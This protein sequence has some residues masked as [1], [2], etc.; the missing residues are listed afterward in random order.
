MPTAT[1]QRFLDALDCSWDDP[2]VR[3]LAG[4]LG[5]CTVQEQDAGGVAVR[6]ARFEDGVELTFRSDRLASIVLTVSDG[7]SRMPGTGLGTVTPLNRE[8]R[9]TYPGFDD[10]V[11]GMTR[12]STRAD[13]RALLGEPLR[14]W[15]AY[16]EYL[17]GERVLS[18][19]F[20]GRDFDDFRE[21]RLLHEDP[22]VLRYDVP[23]SPV[24]KRRDGRVFLS[25]PVSLGVADTLWEFEITA[26]HVEALRDRECFEAL[27]SKLDGRT[28]KDE[29]R[30]IIDHVCDRGARGR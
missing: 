11:P 21:L 2:A 12:D 19:T 6:T 18:V 25:V 22:I 7:T 1:L 26:T 15:F 3:D 4:H 30:R 28:D 8:P 9:A 27:R 23:W 13:V 24:A 29:M 17:I 20:Y 16:D 5:P 14:A 10:L